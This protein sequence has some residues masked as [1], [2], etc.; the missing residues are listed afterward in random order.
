M[1]QRIVRI[2]N[3]PGAAAV[4]GFVLALLSFHAPGAA[5]ETPFLQL[6]TEQLAPL[7]MSDDNGKT[8]RGVAAD[9]VH[10]LTRRSGIE[11]SMQL[12]SW[13]RAIE[14]AKRQSDTCVFAA[15]RTPE[16]EANFKWVGPIARGDWA[17]FGPAEKVGRITGLE[18]V[19]GARIGG[20]LGDAA[21]RY[22]EDFGY[23]VVV[24]Y[25]DDVT[26][27]NLLAGRLDYWVSSRKAAHAMIAENHAE[28]RLAELFHIRSVDYYL[29]CNLQTS[30]SVINSLR[31][32]L[33]QIISD[34]TFEKIEAKY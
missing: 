22:L 26:V 13:N 31:V 25:S 24:S 30:D 12:M 8:I 17:L 16:R 11:S 9:K 34:G 27:K 18:Q 14:L 33:K 23:R 3:R 32:A 10:E 5:A 19:R 7:N 1:R 20:Y 6:T 15:A 4:W 2:D 28:G 21:G 29:A